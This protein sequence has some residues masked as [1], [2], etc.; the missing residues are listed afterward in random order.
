MVGW[1]RGWGV[2]EDWAG[3]EREGWWVARRVKS[4]NMGFGRGRSESAE[5]GGNGG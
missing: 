2:V 5:L 1:G 3:G 4:I